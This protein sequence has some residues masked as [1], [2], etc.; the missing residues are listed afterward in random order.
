M[1]SYFDINKEYNI[2]DITD[3]IAL[4]LNINPQKFRTIVEQK[5]HE[6]DRIIRD[7]ELMSKILLLL[8]S[9]TEI[10]QFETK[11]KS[12]KVLRNFQIMKE[13]LG[14]LQVLALVKKLEKADTCDDVINSFLVVLNNKFEGVNNVLTGSLN[15]TGGSKNINYY[16]KYLKYKI[17]NK[18]LELSELSS[19]D[20]NYN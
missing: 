19:D 4:K 16:S 11:L 2:L 14:E 3:E 1:N 18:I 8:Q 13:R 7:R 20:A 5:I 15:Q 6:S 9:D 17:K 12:E 10:N